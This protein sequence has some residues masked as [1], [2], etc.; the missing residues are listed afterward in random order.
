MSSSRASDIPK[1]SHDEYST[2]VFK[3]IKSKICDSINK[4]LKDNIV[5][6]T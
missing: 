6:L 3:K 1:T 2:I 5:L 4:E